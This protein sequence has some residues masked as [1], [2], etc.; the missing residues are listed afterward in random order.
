MITSI[1]PGRGELSFV[2]ISYTAFYQITRIFA[3]RNNLKVIT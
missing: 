2:H 1:Q 3:N